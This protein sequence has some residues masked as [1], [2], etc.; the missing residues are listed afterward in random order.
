MSDVQN[1]FGHPWMVTV[2]L[3]HYGI[4]CERVKRVR[5]IRGNKWKSEIYLYIYLL[6]R[7]IKRTNQIAL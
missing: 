4:I 3:D 5:H 6:H 7:H 2:F 1:N